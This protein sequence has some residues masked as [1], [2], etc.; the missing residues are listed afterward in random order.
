MRTLSMFLGVVKIEKCYFS[1]CDIGEE[2]LK[3]LA[4]HIFFY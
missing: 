4:K 2:L 1:E 3:S